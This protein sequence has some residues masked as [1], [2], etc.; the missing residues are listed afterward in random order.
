[1]LRVNGPA[2]FILQ[3]KASPI[4]P[5]KKKRLKIMKPYRKRYT[6]TKS[7]NSIKILENGFLCILWQSINIKLFLWYKKE[8][9]TDFAKLL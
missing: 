9:R 8:I 5:C 1:M 2:M 4:V 7:Y 3:I 6:I